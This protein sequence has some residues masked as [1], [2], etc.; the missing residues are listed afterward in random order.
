MPR[1]F[2]HFF[3]FLS[4]KFNLLDIGQ[5]FFLTFY[6]VITV[7]RE[8]SE[9]SR[10][11]KFISIF[12]YADSYR[13]DIDVSTPLSDNTGLNRFKEQPLSDDIGWLWLFSLRWLCY[14]TCLFLLFLVVFSG[15]QCHR[16]IRCQIL[17]EIVLISNL[18]NFDYGH[19]LY[20][21]R[22]CS[23]RVGLLLLIVVDCTSIK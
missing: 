15:N 16:Q 3:F 8:I 4:C 1:I 13:Y 20:E 12:R 7:I 17:H 10:Y 23:A 9:I 22:N 2:S 14:G 18:P 11:L 19:S 5:T 21:P 6:A